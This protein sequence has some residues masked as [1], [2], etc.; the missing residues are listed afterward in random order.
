VSGAVSMSETRCLVTHARNLFYV[1]QVLA[2]ESFKELSLRF[3]HHVRALAEGD[4][5]NI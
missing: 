5:I 2:L 1:S 3:I 4:I